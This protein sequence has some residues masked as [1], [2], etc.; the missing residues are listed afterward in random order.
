MNK[1]LSFFVAAPA[2]MASAMA[3]STAASI[4]FIATDP[5]AASAWK[6]Y[7]SPGSCNQSKA[8]LLEWS[9]TLD[10]RTSGRDHFHGAPRNL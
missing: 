2:E 3:N 4:L 5:H 8:N 9:R 7:F 1:T 10:Y 6:R